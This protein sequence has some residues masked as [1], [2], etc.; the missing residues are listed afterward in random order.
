MKEV[1]DYIV[2]LLKSR[3][4]PMILVFIVL[5]SVLVHRLFVLQIIKGDSY[6][7]DLSSS[8]Q[9]DMSVAAARV[10]RLT[11]FSAYNDLS[12]AVKISDSGRYSDNATKNTTINNS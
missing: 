12:Y 4:F 11:V 10:S 2:S 8:I 7:E 5:I 1:F 9:K 6:V 3:I